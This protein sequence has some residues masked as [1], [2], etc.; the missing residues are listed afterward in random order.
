MT[1][2]LGSDR[3]DSSTP[4]QDCTPS[5]FAALADDREV[6]LRRIFASNEQ[7]T[8]VLIAC[9]QMACDIDVLNPPREVAT[10][11]R[12]VRIGD[13][14]FDV[15]G[16]LYGT[17]ERVLARATSVISVTDPTTAESVQIAPWL[18]RTLQRKIQHG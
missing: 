16:R 7:L 8:P 3:L 11:F 2:F 12:V 15:E 14:T 18:E 6:W 4:I 17:E 5:L 13:T 9:Q 1:T 10:E